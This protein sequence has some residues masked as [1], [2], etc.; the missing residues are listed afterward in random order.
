MTQCPHTGCKF[1]DCD[2]PST[3]PARVAKIGQRTPGPEPIT[4]TSW[5]DHLPNLALAVLLVAAVIVIS[6][7]ATVA[8]LG[9]AK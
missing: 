3:C 7:A 9:A 4:G 5:R 1:P 8:V 2:C 6:V